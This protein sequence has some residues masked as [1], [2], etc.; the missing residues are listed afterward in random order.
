MISV[1][2]LITFVSIVQQGSFSAAADT[3]GQTPSA[4]SRTLSRLEEQLNIRLLT[5]TTRHLDEC[6]APDH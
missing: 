5:R 2:S 6:L 1:K 4:V 3:L